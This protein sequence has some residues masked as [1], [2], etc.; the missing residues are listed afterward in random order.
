MNGTVL[1]IFAP[2][3]RFPWNFCFQV[4]T[5][6]TFFKKIQGKSTPSPFTGLPIR[7]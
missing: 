3:A 2:N 7:V 4:E 6:K 5:E 1:F